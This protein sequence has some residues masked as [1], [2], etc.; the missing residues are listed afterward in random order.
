LSCPTLYELGFEAAVSEWL[1][2]KIG[3]E[4]GIKTE[5]EDDGSS[6]PLLDDVRVLMF[7]SVRELLI[8]VVKHSQASQVKVVVRKADDEIEVRIEDN[9]IGFNPQ[10]A[11]AM[12]ARR[13]EFGLFNIKERLEEVGGKLLIESAPGAGC[14]ATIRAPLKRKGIDDE[15]NKAAHQGNGN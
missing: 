7:R 9:G 12:A 5:F 8:N 1:E 10:E 3:K 2:E 15:R 4:Y 6:K 11:A 14:K 13:G